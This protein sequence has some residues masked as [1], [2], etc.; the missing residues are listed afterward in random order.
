GVIGGNKAIMELLAPLGPVYHAG[1]F[2]GNPVSMTAGLKTIE[3]IERYR[4]PERINTYGDRLR[5][6]LRELVRDSGVAAS[7]SGVGS[8]FQIFFTADGRRVRNYADALGCDKK[9][10]MRLFHAMLSSG[11]F[12]P[13]SPFETNFISFAHTEEE[14]ERTIEAFKHNL[15]KS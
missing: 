13:P 9:R 15:T 7:V 11:I 6:A 8:M 5:G 4:V 2:S 12:L 14:I 3:L 1:T 10:Y